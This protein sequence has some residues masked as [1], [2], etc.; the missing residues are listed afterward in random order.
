MPLTAN[1]DGYISAGWYG[2]T[3]ARGRDS[4][5]GND[6]LLMGT[7]HF[8]KVLSLDLGAA[9]AQLEDS[10]SGYW[11]GVQGGAKFNQAAGDNRNKFAVFDRLQASF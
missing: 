4:Q 6:L 2:N 9:Y 11:Q 7:Y 10:V 1:L 3:D 5:V 8:N